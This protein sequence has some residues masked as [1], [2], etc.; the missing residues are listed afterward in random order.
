MLY[1][2]ALLSVAYLEAFQVTGKPVYAQIAR[3]ILD[4]IL[5]D[6]T[7][8]EGGFYSAEDA[9][10][11]GEEGK[12]A[13]WLEEE[14]DRAL[15]PAEAELFKKVYGVTQQGNFEHGTNILNLQSEFGWEI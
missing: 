1:D 5:S 8:P 6:M 4:Y 15:T 9:D 10:S 11:E 3:E 7:S 12:F 2:N 14:I 13:V